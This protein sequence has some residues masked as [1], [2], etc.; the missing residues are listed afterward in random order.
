M[1]TTR[2]STGAT[3]AKRGAGAPS[4]PSR[5]RSTATKG[6]PTPRTPRRAASPAPAK[7]AAVTS[8]S[9]SSKKGAAAGGS[10]TDA[11]TKAMRLVVKALGIYVCFIYWGIVQERVTTTEY[12]PAPGVGGKPGRYSSMIA[13]NGACVLI[14][15]CVRA[16]DS[17][18]RSIDSMG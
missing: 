10:G 14:Y 11:K 12:Q 6:P 9:S 17:I 16:C 5:R 3:P 15:V 18:D 8:S 7:R 4:T 1:V 2:H 13:L